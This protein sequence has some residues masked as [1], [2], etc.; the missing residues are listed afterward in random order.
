MLDGET[1]SFANEA[2]SSRLD[3]AS[4]DDDGLPVGFQ[5]SVPQIQVPAFQAVF[6]REVI[7]DVEILQGL[8]GCFRRTGRQRC[9]LWFRTGGCFW[10]VAPRGQ[11][12]PL[13]FGTGG[14]FWLV[15]PC[16]QDGPLRFGTR[17]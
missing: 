4:V 14:C 12:G 7:V 6:E 13:G 11:D 5:G 9:P 10:L 8:G 17:R 16:G 3:E 2:G 1:A 15:A